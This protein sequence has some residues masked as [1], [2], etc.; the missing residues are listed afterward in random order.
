MAIEAK[1]FQDFGYGGPQDLLVNDHNNNNNNACGFNFMIPQQQQQQQKLQKQHQFLR[2]FDHFQ[3]LSSHQKH[4]NTSF[5]NNHHHQQQQ[6][7]V[8]DFYPNL[9]AQIEKHGMELDG[10]ITL[11]VSR[12]SFDILS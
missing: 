3:S 2:D 7:Q 1:M 12:F 8:M 4:Q 5:I 9:S 10:F 6:Q 11:Q